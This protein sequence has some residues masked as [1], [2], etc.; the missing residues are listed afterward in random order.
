MPLPA[1]RFEH[2]LITGASAGLGAEFARALAPR[3]AELTLT[4]RREGRLR[5]L[6]EELEGSFPVRCRVIVEDLS[7]PSG[8][9]ALLETLEREGGGDVDLLVNNAGFGR[10][11]AIERFPC[12]D[13]LAMIRLN[14][15]ALCALSCGLWPVLARIPGRGVIHVASV[16]GHTAIPYFCVYAATKA[17]VRSF[18]QGLWYEG[19][20]RGVRVLSLCPGPVKTEFGDVAQVPPGGGRLYVPAARVVEVA[21]RDYERGRVESLPGA[22]NRLLAL[23]AKWL[24]MRVLLPL[25]GKRARPR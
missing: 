21:L 6:A 11:G 19:R 16:A 25:A 13:Y 3:A 12:E 15:E 1:P 24:P 10:Y 7:R 5:A 17:F 22:V 2:C 8:A 23:T 4:A 9:A 18:S 20:A 14:V